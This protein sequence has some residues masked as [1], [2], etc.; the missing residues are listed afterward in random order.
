MGGARR[1]N[2]SHSR[3]LPYFRLASFG[4]TTNGCLRPMYRGRMMAYLVRPWITLALLHWS[5]CFFF[6]QSSELPLLRAFV[7]L[8]TTA[9]IFI[10]DKYHNSDLAPKPSLQL[11]VYW[12]RWDFIGIAAEGGD[13]MQ[14]ALDN[15]AGFHESNRLVDLNDDLLAAVGCRWSCPP[16]LAPAAW[17]CA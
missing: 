8:T 15:P 11:E 4:Q 2:M 10:S 13:Q 14:A 7:W 9:N 17:V 1:R 12:L 16:L 3:R 5:W 6:E